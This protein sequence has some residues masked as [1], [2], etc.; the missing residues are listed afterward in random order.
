MAHVTPI[1]PHA[2]EAT[3]FFI[4]CEH[5]PCTFD[6]LLN[7]ALDFIGYDRIMH[8]S[9]LGKPAY[10][11]ISPTSTSIP[12]VN[13]TEQFSSSAVMFVR[14]NL[15]SYMSTHLNNLLAVNWAGASRL[16]I[17]VNLTYCILP[18]ELTF[19]IKYPNYTVS[20]AYLIKSVQ[21]KLRY[22]LVLRCLVHI[23]LF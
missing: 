5:D 14:I 17:I 10:V 3:E 23:L 22:Y 11:F 15:S 20:M 13:I 18:N 19:K 7:N 2:E 16:F 21:C 8:I 9:N 6:K 12:Y 1:E 4:I